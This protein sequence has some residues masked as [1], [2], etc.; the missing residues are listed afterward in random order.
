MRKNVY[1]GAAALL[2]T[3]SLSACGNDS[4]SSSNNGDSVVKEVDS[5]EDLGKCEKDIFGEIVYVAENDSL[6]E[7]TSEGWVA[8]DSSAIEKLLESS[9]ANSDGKSSSS[10]KVDSSETKKI[11]TVKV[12]SVMLTGFAQKGPF[13]KG[14]AVTVYGL[15]SL[16]EK[17]KT[18]FTGKVSGDSGAYNVEK[19][20]LPNQYALVE[21][22]GNYLSEVTGKKTSGTKLKLNAIVDLSEG[23]AIHANVNIF[24]E[25]EYARV[26]HLVAKEKFNVPAAKKR[27]TKELLALFGSDEQADASLSSTDI[28]LMDTTAAGTTLLSASI[29]LSG[30]LSVTRFAGRL[31]EI[32]EIFAATGKL[33]SAKLRIELADWAADAGSDDNYAAIYENV[34]AQKI[35]SIVPNFESVLHAFWTSEYGL[36]PC[37]ETI[38]ES[39]KKME[40]KLSDNYG[41]GYACTSKRWHKISELDT[42]LGLCTAKKEGSFKEN[43]GDKSTEYYVCRNQMWG[44]KVQDALKLENGKWVVCQT[45]ILI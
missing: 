36:E 12:E 10:F 41:A 7:C 23:K 13:E 2:A 33:D 45:T 20:D 32:A 14:S 9:S 25:L 37:T 40:N 43:K 3:F 22:N 16:L 38:E 42:E 11:E 17:T 29:L 19:I 30:E 39:V 15:D 4:N 21:V 8:T 24:T 26:K 34:K 6:Y 44:G 1:M 27:A 35:V 28:S 5:V 18:K 31:G